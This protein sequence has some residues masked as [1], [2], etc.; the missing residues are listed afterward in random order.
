VGREYRGQ[1]LVVIGVLLVT[2]SPVL[3]ATYGYG[4]DYL[5]FDSVRNDWRVMLS[6]E[7]VNG[8]PGML[9][10]HAPAFALT[11]SMAAM[12]W[13]RVVSIAGIAAVGITLARWS[14]W[15]R[16]ESTALGLT[17]VLLPAFWVTAAWSLMFVVPL[18]LLAAMWAARTA[19]KPVR[20]L[21]LLTAAGL[22]YQPAAAAYLLPL[23]FAWA[24]RRPSM[25]EL[26]THG[27]VVTAAALITVGAWIAGQSFAGERAFARVVPNPTSSAA[28]FAETSIPHALLAVSSPVGAVIGWMLLIW[29]LRDRW[30]LLPLVPAAYLPCLMG[31]SGTEAQ[32]TLIVVG[33]LL[34]LLVWI[35]VRQRKFAA[36]LVAYPATLAIAG[37]VVT[38]TYIAKP[39]QLEW[40]AVQQI[41]ATRGAIA[42]E[43]AS[44]SGIAQGPP[45]GEFGY[46][47]T[48]YIWA[49]PPMVRS[50][51]NNKRVV[52]IQPGEPTP[53]GYRR[54][55]MDDLLRRP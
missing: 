23:A 9:A 1:A 15:G 4:D 52:W 22:I 48:E 20:S 12:V 41:A 55:R 36:A 49:I 10:M 3:L 28:E 21:L 38:T 54:I 40:E 47:A 19:D 5:L 46:T 11:P 51:R 35:A 24:D 2:Y 34:V 29:L 42:V 26:V 17:V 14:P 13:M 43:P 7:L 45:V 8:R 33:P 6:V 53:S 39:Q 50:A 32:R 27:K 18:A 31:N 37:L 30:W 44:W 25:D 16:R